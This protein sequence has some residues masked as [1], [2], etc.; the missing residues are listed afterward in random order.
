[1]NGVPYLLAHARRLIAIGWTQQADAR[2][3][4]DTPVHPWDSRAVRW[5]LLGALVAAVEHTA[6][7]R[8]EPA[9]LQD[10]ARTCILL[11]ET[12]DSDSLQHWNDTRDRSPL[13]VLGALDDAAAL[14]GGDQD[15]DPLRPSLN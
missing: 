4:D 5:S 1:M 6:T 14:T 10:L 2:D 7:D 8:G 15:D 13:D 11:A 12:L 9:A 3:A